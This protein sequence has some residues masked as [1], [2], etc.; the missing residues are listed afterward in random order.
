MSTF[1][2]ERVGEWEWVNKGRVCDTQEGK[3]FYQVVVT[4]DSL[5]KAH[6]PF[7]KCIKLPKLAR[8]VGA[9]VTL[10]CMPIVKVLWDVID[11]GA[12]AYYFTLLETGSLIPKVIARNVCNH[13]LHEV[14]I[15]WIRILYGRALQ[16]WWKRL[17]LYIFETCAGLH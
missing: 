5:T 9:V 14:G 8:F 15:S 6:Q 11:V 4:V 2:W 1:E 16:F 12:D 17:C 13:G 10:L 3:K 7:C